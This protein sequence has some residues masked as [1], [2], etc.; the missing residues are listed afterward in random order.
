MVNVTVNGAP[1]DIGGISVPTVDV[2]YEIA[3]NDGNPP[4]PI[5]LEAA[6]LS[7]EPAEGNTF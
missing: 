5:P 2:Y 3:S 4:T 1:L 7:D 6:E